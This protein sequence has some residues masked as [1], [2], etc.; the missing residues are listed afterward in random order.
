MKLG[1]I[2][3]LVI[4]SA[5]LLF[6]MLSPAIA[7]SGH[8]AKWSYEGE[9]GPS[10]WG[11]L[12]DAFSLCKNG[13]SQSPVNIGEI[14][15]AEAPPLEIHY[16]ETPLDVLNNG[17]TVQFN[18][19]P[20]SFIKIGEKKF[21]L[22]QFHFHAP[23]EHIVKGKPL[24]MEMHLV[25]KNDLGELAVLGVFF[26]IAEKNSKLDSFWKHLPDKVNEPTK[27]AEIKVNAKD[28]LPG[29]LK[30]Y[31]YSGSLTTPPCS[32]GVMWNVLNQPLAVTESQLNSFKALVGNN[33]RP[34]QALN[35]R[36]VTHA[37]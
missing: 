3:F 1:K 14:T 13:E 6:G 29:N 16:E 10:H 22:L 33:A 8:G 32:E 34:S 4:F 37:K 20:G 21:G 36:N 19:Q 24:D 23:S 5:V 27:M 11:G 25:H 12:N 18:Y 26:T 2:I 17:H 15:K 30:Y 28:L 7:D 31:F 35:T 9:T